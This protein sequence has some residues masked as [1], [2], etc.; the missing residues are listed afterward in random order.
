MKHLKTIGLAAIAAMG[1]MAFL[2]AGTAS[3]TTLC[4][5]KDSPDCT[6]TYT[7]GTKWD[8]S[9]KPKT[10]AKITNTAGEELA[11]CTEVTIKGTT[12]ITSTA[13]GKPFPMPIE[14]IEFGGCNN[15]LKTVKTGTLD[16]EWIEGTSNGT[17]KDEGTEV[18]ASILGVSCTYGAGTGTSFGTMVGG[19]TP[20]DSVSAAEN[21]TAGG[22]LCPPSIVLDAQLVLTEPHSLFFTT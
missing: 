4:T 17:E 3:A 8:E 13:K 18:T 5:T 9:L 12:T 14:S 15:A 19:E 16:T 1:L 10:S 11:T 2:G 7:E 6:M 21:K 22:F 20:E